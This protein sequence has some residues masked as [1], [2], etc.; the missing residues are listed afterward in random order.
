MVVNT[1]QSHVPVAREQISIPASRTDFWIPFVSDPDTFLGVST[2]IPNPSKIWN[3]FGGLRLGC[4]HQVL[5]RLVSACCRHLIGGPRVGGGVSRGR[6]GAEVFELREVGPGAGRTRHLLFRGVHFYRGILSSRG[7]LRFSRLKK[8]K[9]NQPRKPM[10]VE[11]SASRS[12]WSENLHQNLQCQ[13]GSVSQVCQLVFEEGSPTKLHYRKKLVPQF[14]PLY[15]RTWSYCVLR[16]SFQPLP[17]PMFQVFPTTFYK[18]AHT[19]GK[20]FQ[21]THQSKPHALRPTRPPQASARPWARRPRCC[22]TT[23]SARRAGPCGR[24]G[25]AE[26][27]A[28]SQEPCVSF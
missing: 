9:N 26:P 14:Y 22:C 2:M 19:S 17:N 12:L 3:M 23:P 18:K 6:P 25:S 15:R 27:G 24:P 1:C 4:E 8:I 5:H 28:W 13:S 21:S 7:T 20:L 16:V 11:A 10:R